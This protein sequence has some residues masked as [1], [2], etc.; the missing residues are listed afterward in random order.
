MADLTDK[1]LLNLW[2]EYVEN[3]R[4]QTALLQGETEAQQKRRIEILEADTELWFKY[5]FP[6]YCYADP[7]S[8]HKAA[9]KRIINNGEW[10]EVRVW[11]RELAKSTRTMMEI[12]FLTLTNKKKYVLLISNS[13]D[14]AER[15]LMPF[16][17][18]LEANQRIIHDYGMQELPGKWEASEFTTRKGA[19]FRALG[20][21][22][23]P[24]G[25][26]NDEARPDVILFDDIDT[27][28]ECRNPDII[29]KKW[30]W[31]EQAAMG[32]RSVSKNTLIIFLGNRIA[33]DCC[34]TRASENADHVSEINIRDANGNST[35]P[36][37]NTEADI[38]RIL[39]KVSY[40]T[41]QKEYFNNPMSEGRVFKELTIGKCPPLNHLQFIIAYAD[42][43]PSNRDRPGNRAKIQN[44]CKAVTLVGYALN[45]FYI[46]KAFVDNTTNANFIEWLYAARSYVA[47][48]T[49][50]YFLIENN[51][52]QNPF[53]EQVLL[54]LIYSKADELKQT[55]LPVTPDDR[56]KPDKYFRIEGTLEPL[57][58][59][60]NLIFN[61]DE[62]DNP[63]MKRLIAQFKGVSANSKTM[64]GPDCVEGAVHIIQMKMI[65]LPKDAMM[66]AKKTVNR[67]RF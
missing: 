27:D 9:T 21:G 47:E 19:A 61:E 51:T 28:E 62:K 7:A 17:G 18:N 54:P 38:D 48:Q 37:K 30:E 52:L 15:L 23:S 39:S 2:T 22:Q 1:Q 14:N 16:K 29:H 42:P 35:W 25:T 57:N 44:S 34:I 36:T 67:K 55:V 32:T 56:K 3:I 8:F 33:E 66:H 6:Q 31:I 5:Y 20:A 43:S 65:E 4:R 60:G 45:K 63:H 46:Y 12:L 13:F 49:Q 53:Y 40:A 11:S 50:P 58:R 10:Y 41:Q 64:D 24:R 26:R 59:M